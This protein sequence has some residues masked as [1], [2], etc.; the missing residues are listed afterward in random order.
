MPVPE[1]EF[2]G[3]PDT[4]DEAAEEEGADDEDDEEDED[5]WEQPGFRRYRK[6]CKEDLKN[7][8]LLKPAS[9][10]K[11]RKWIIQKQAWEMFCDFCRRTDYCNPAAFGMH[12]FNDFE[13]YGIMELLDNM[14]STRIN[15]LGPPINSVCSS[16]SSTSCAR[17]KTKKRPYGAPGLC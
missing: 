5:D 6:V 4:V 1:S 12:V 14:V 9:E 3:P 8:R 17:G 13:G 16:Y 15:A 11:D 10:F 2:L 7:G